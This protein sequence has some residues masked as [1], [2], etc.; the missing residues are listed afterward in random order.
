MS[1]DN[2]KDSWSETSPNGIIRDKIDQINLSL[3]S[4]DVGKLRNNKEC[5]WLDTEIKGHHRLNLSLTF[6]ETSE[7]ATG[8]RIDINR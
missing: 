8:H 1:W 7:E 5:G 3:I 4:T 2:S 6:H